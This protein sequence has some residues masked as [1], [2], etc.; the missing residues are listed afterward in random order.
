[1][2]ENEKKHKTPHLTGCF[3]FGGKIIILKPGSFM[4]HI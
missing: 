4:L 2:A 1:M 3:V